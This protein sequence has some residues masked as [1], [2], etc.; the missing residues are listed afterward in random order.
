M[1]HQ[2]CNIANIP[3]WWIFKNALLKSLVHN[4]AI[5]AVCSWERTALHNSNW[6]WGNAYLT[7]HSHS[8]LETQFEKSILLCYLSTEGDARFGVADPNERVMSLLASA[9]RWKARSKH[10]FICSSL[11]GLPP[12]AKANRLGAIL[13]Q[14]RKILTTLMFSIQQLVNFPKETSS[15]Q[16]CYFIL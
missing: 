4:H 6:S 14:A 8:N 16:F 7:K 3:L 12:G 9:W 1:W 13:W 2:L 5:W 15:P 11:R 10:R